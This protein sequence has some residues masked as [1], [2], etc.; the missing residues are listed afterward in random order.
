MRGARVAF[1]AIFLVILASG[2]A[3]WKWMHAPDEEVC[4][5]CLRPVHA[6]SKTVAYFDGRR[7]VFCCPSCAASQ[8]RQTGKTVT[9]SELT[10][11]ETG[12]RLR[13][14]EAVLVEGSDVNPC[15]AGAALLDEQK[16]AAAEPFDRCAPGLLAFANE[17]AA[18]GFVARHGGRLLRFGDIAARYGMP[19]LNPGPPISRSLSAP[20]GTF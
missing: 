19:P 16:H 7:T 15:T 14:G 11:F 9:V 20:R 4:V 17:R 13:P 8:H 6:M 12:A 10:D 1:I 5:V 2:Y 18:A 3:G